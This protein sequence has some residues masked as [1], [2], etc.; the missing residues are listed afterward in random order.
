MSLVLE[1][2]IALNYEYDEDDDTLYAW[3]GERPSEA[4]TYE[5]AD[6]HLVRL[7]PETKE[8]VGVT[9]FEF[10]AR[11]GDQDISLE[12]ETE[13]E[14]AIPWIPRIA[15]KQRETIAQKRTLHRL[16]GHVTA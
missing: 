6:G 10:R 7:D 3:A 1:S 4:I 16:S 5:T 12:W 8:F 13:V 2:Q 9:I 11:W 15:R 14:R